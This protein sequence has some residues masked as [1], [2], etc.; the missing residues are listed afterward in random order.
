MHA[1]CTVCSSLADVGAALT[2]SSFVGGVLVAVAST[3][4]GTSGG[5]IVITSVVDVFS[6]FLSLSVV[7]SLGMIH[8]VVDLQREEEESQRSRRYR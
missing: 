3:D 8:G 4:A 5:T 2:S 6:F 7:C 1:V